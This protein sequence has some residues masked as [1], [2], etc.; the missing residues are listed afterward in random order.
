MSPTRRQAMMALLALPLGTHLAA[1][2]RPGPRHRV[3]LGNGE[4]LLLDP[5]G[6]LR[7]W[8]RHPVS[9]GT[10]PDSLGLGHNG[11]LQPFTLATVPGLTNVVAASAGWNC[12]FAVLSDGRLL[13]WGVNSNGRL[14]TTTQAQMETLASWSPNGS[15]RPLPLS[16]RFDA[17]NGGRRRARPGAGPRRERLRLG[18]GQCG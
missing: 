13:A 3:I 9:D 14:G 8:V 1:Q 15:N 10:A 17:V 11:P 5:D 16:T 2:V 12:T 4:G 7:M 6:T 18:C